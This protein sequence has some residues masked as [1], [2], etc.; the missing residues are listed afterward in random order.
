MCEILDYRKISDDFTEIIGASLHYFEKEVELDMN[1]CSAVEIM[2]LQK[3][4]IKR[5]QNDYIFH[6]KV[7]SIVSRL[8]NSTQKAETEGMTYLE[9]PLLNSNGGNDGR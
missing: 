8:L 9:E 7:D 4:W 2:D 6:N 3:G 5:Y 1:T